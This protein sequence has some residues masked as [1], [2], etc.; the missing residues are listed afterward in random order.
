VIAIKC[1]CNRSA[2]KSNLPIPRQVLFDTHDAYTGRSGMC[3]TPGTD[4]NKADSGPLQV[5]CNIC[6]KSFRTLIRV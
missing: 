2:N 4:V 5:R 6:F 1:N 3:N